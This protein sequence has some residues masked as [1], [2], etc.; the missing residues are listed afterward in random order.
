MNLT[1]AALVLFSAVLHPLWN[2]VV[3]RQVRTDTAYRIGH[4]VDGIVLGAFG[5]T[6]V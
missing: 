3:K 2:A 6:E 5:C 4:R 1:I